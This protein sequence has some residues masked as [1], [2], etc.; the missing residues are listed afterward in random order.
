MNQIE[1]CS[2]TGAELGPRL[3]PCG[4]FEGAADPASGA[5]LVDPKEALEASGLTGE[6][7]KSAFEEAMATHQMRITDNI[8]KYIDNMALS[9]DATEIISLQEVYAS[10]GRFLNA[11]LNIDDGRYRT[12]VHVYPSKGL[13]EKDA[14]RALTQ[15]ILD[16]IKDNG[17][18]TSD[19]FVTGIQS[20]ADELKSK[21]KESFEVST[22]IA[23]FFVFGLLYLH[24]RKFALV[25]PTLVPLLVSVIWMLGIMQLAGI[26]ITILNFVATPLIIG[27]GIDDG[28]HIVEKYLHRD[29]SNITKLIAGCG[30]AVTLTSLTT[31]FGFMSLFM[32]EYSG[33]HSLGLCAILGVFCCWLG[34]VIILPLLM[35]RF[36]VK[37]VRDTVIKSP[38]EESGA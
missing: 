1:Q 27:I 11:F 9:L 34:S 24:F 33:F 16:A 28:V 29:S 21:V 14:T 32:A 30:K 8:R 20:I 36:Q 4:G 17:G 3:E 38:S 23:V 13:W 37:F 26:D 25:A 18:D 22:I 12:V 10:E 35:D 15:T 31:I 5:E 19:V 6:K 2:D 7:L